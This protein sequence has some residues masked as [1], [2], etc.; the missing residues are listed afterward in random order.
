[1]PLAATTHEAMAD[2]EDISI[3]MMDG[4]FAVRVEVHRTLLVA[5]AGS[6]QN[7]PAR[8]LAI[9]EAH[10][11][12]VERVASAKYDQ[13]EYRRYANGAVVRITPTDW[14]RHKRASRASPVA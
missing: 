10:R 2:L 9:L 14:E 4:E 11:D 5:L 3:T 7:S 8:Q 6:G 13:G 12:Q 1:M